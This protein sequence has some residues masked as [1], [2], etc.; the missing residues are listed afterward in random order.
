MKRLM[1]DGA[2]AQLAMC[3]PSIQEVRVTALVLQAWWHTPISPLRSKGVMNLL[4]REF[5]T[6]LS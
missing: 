5:K 3:R 2:I 1:G 6:S 4:H